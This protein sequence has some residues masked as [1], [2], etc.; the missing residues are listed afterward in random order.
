METSDRLG[1]YSLL[2][3]IDSKARSRFKTA[4]GASSIAA[5]EGSSGIALGN[6]FGSNIA[7]IALILGITAL[8]SPIAVRSE[9][10]RKE[11]PILLG[12][13]FFAA[14]QLLDANLSK[15]DAFSLL[16]LFILLISWSIWTGLRGDKD[17]LAE[18]FGEELNSTSR[19]VGSLHHDIVHASPE[20]TPHLPT[21]LFAYARIRTRKRTVERL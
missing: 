1:P 2:R 10:I 11:L 7:N 15:D 21:H 16:G 9:I 20:R 5:L 8:I 17:A 3:S 19:S 4:G 18:E 12:L 14:W 13:T 6:A